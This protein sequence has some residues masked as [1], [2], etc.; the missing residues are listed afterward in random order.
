MDNIGRKIIE[1]TGFIISSEQEPTYQNDKDYSNN[2][3][4]NRTKTDPNRFFE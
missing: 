2:Q 1:Q 3:I 4:K